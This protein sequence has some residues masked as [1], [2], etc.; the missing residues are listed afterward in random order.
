[1]HVFVWARVFCG[2]RKHQSA[3]VD[4]SGT[5]K[6]FHLTEIEVDLGVAHA[7]H[8]DGFQQLVTFDEAL[9]R[10]Q[11]PGARADA[12]CCKIA[13]VEELASKMNTIQILLR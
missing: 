8:H 7:C 4:C 11:S 3:S 6:K 12:R 10:L 5:I 9:G 2:T 13:L 1:M